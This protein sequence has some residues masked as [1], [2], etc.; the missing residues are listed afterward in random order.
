M[1]I[2][3]NIYGASQ[4]EKIIKTIKRRVIK[5]IKKKNKQNKIKKSDLPE[6]DMNERYFNA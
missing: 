2:I 5:V 3:D 6:L 4:R 1:R